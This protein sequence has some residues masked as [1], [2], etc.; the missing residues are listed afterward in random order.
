MSV[1]ERP[2]VPDHEKSPAAGRGN[3]RTAAGSAR[4]KRGRPRRAAAS[5]L[6]DDLQEIDETGEVGGVTTLEGGNGG[7]DGGGG[8][9]G[10]L[11]R[12]R[13]MRRFLAGLRA[14]DA[15][16]FSVRLEPL[17]DPLMAEIADI[18]NSVVTKQGRLADEL[19][20]VAL[21]VG[22]EGKM[23]DRATIGPAGGLWA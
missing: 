19:N 1:G 13:A 14:V 11:E 18:F 3:G 23:R 17:G 12:E 6:N 9:R 21:S 10:G 7:G 5:S 20:R 4:G 15:G 2:E 22:R 8:G 16:D